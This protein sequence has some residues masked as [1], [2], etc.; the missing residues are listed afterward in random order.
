[1]TIVIGIAAPDGVILAADSRTTY[2]SGEHHRVASDTSHKVFSV[3]GRFAVAT[4]GISFV[5]GQTI[6][7]QIDEFVGQLDPAVTEVRPFA[8]AL[9]KFF[10][11]RVKKEYSEEE[12]KDVYALLGFLVAGYDAAGIG[13]LLEVS[14]PG[15]E[16]SGEI[17]TGSTGTL[18]RGQTDVVRRLI[19]GIDWS[20]LDIG[21]TKIPEPIQKGLEN[22]E[23]NLLSPITLQDSVDFATFLIRT[24]IDMQRFS[25]GLLSRPGSIPGC[26]GPISVIAVTRAGTEWVDQPMLAAAA[27]EP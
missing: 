22:L 4:Y 25:D 19:K 7:G 14:L 18:W 1:M 10:D 23:Y 8:D 20:Q 11:E 24:T 26:G 3:R 21:D 5:G 15:P 17:N 9:A 2:T 13:Q 16:V 12:L 6:A 27:T